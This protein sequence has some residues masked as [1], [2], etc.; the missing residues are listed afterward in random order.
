MTA[1]RADV[2]ELLAA[3]YG[4][5]TIARQLAVSIGSVTRAR[6]LL[7]VK[8]ARRGIKQAGTVEDLFWRRTQP[9]DDGHLLWTGSRTTKGTPVLKWGGRS[10]DSYTAYRIAYRIHHGHDP[11]GTCY[12]ACEQ[13]GC[14]APSHIADSATTPRPARRRRRPRADEDQ[15]VALLRA[16]RTNDAIARQLNTD[17]KR[18]A[19]IRAREGLPPAVRRKPTFAD[20]WEANTAPAD[21]GHVR[22]TGRLRDGVTPSLVYRD[23]DYSARRA[24]F[25]ELHGRLAVG[26]VRPGCGWDGCVRPEHME[27]RPMRDRLAGQVAAI[28][29]EAA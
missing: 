14:V 4:D 12:P 19:R 9:A 7:G 24:G 6:T 26:M 13:P 16:G 2:A 28:F 27:D 18:V 15:I 5:R 22:W 10:G 21:G 1:V 11:Q 25:E 8:A 20:K 23:R 3:G 17:G 29:G